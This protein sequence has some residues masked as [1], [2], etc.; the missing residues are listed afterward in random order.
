VRDALSMDT[1]FGQPIYPYQL[2]DR[3]T[4]PADRTYF[5]SL[6]SALGHR[7]DALRSITETYELRLEQ[8]RR[9]IQR[10]THATGAFST[11][12]QMLRNQYLSLLIM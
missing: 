9:Q 5:D 4:P 1:E 2:I 11:V 10:S 3:D 12:I 8:V 7:S 6:A